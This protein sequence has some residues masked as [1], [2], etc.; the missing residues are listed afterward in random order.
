MIKKSPPLIGTIGKSDADGYDL[1][2]ERMNKVELVSCGQRH[3]VRM[4][5]RRRN[6][7]KKLCLA[8]S[9]SYNKTTFS[10]LKD[11]K[12]YMLLAAA[13][14]VAVGVVS[15]LPRRLP[16]QPSSS[17]PS[18]GAVTNLIPFQ[19]RSA[20]PLSVRS[21]GVE[22]KG[23]TYHLVGLSSIKFELDK[24]DRLTAEIQGGATTF[25]KVD[26]D[27]SGAVFDAE[28]QMLGAAR[29]QCKVERLWL[30]N[31]LTMAQ[32]INLDFGVSLE[33]ARAAFFAVSISNQKVLT[34]DEWQK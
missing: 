30:G 1:Q 32:T 27:I 17:V 31:L 10:I 29:V 5:R 19:L 18:A 6:S 8:V 25:D 2:T 12:T 13:A 28:G 3:G 4:C 24:N 7:S 23:N 15:L 9:Y 11:M 21:A 14:M 16:A 26:Y 33:Y 22:W 34:P 20:I